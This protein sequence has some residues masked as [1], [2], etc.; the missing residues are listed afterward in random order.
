MNSYLEYLSRGDA[1][2]APPSFCPADPSAVA[3]KPSCP[4]GGE[5]S[6]LGSRLVPDAG[7]A[8]GPAQRPAA[9]SRF[10][11]CALAGAYDSGPPAA[12]DFNVLPPSSGY[13]LPYG[14]SAQVE[15]AGGGHLRYATSIFS[16]NG[17]QLPVGYSA[18]AEQSH[19][20]PCLK[21]PPGVQLGGFQS[22]SPSPGTYP[23]PTS[24]AS[25]GALGTFEWMKVKRNAPKKSK[26]SAYG[27]PS[28]PSTVRTH[29][30]TKQLTELEKEFHFNKYLTR[31][32]R[33]EIAHSLRL[34][35]TQVKIWF[36]NRRMK[37]KK[38]E[39]EGLL[40]PSPAGSPSAESPAKPGRN[41]VLPKTSAD[42]CSTSCCDSYLRGKEG[43][44]SD[45]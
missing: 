34:N 38:R 6:H 4:L 1:L 9:A 16:G 45:L 13:A 43:R 41:S 23:K 27:V 26:L 11:A 40:I 29:F 15:D 31:A 30:S 12:A 20:L 32:R 5:S 18:S 3:L 2:R 8:P 36:Q 44:V 25:G 37:Q 39:R 21:E 33:V 14:A 28:P 17:L 10:A 42:R 35:D 22:V 7:P 24:P 19:F